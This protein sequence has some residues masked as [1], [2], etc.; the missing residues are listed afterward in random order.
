[1]CTYGDS[2]LFL[3]ICTRK[4][5]TNHSKETFEKD[6]YQE[7]KIEDKWKRI[8]R[9][10]LVILSIVTASVFCIMVLFNKAL[11]I[12]LLPCSLLY[13]LEQSNKA[14][15]DIEVVQKAFKQSIDE[16]LS[17]LEWNSLVGIA[18]FMC[19]VNLYKIPNKIII[20]IEGIKNDRLS[21][22]ILIIF[23]IFISTI[24][25]FLTGVLIF[26]LIKNIILFFETVFYK[27]KWSICRRICTRLIGKSEKIFSWDFLSIL[28]CERMKRNV[29]IM[30]IAIVPII[31]IDVLL[32]QLYILYRVVLS[33]IVNLVFFLKSTKKLLGHI[34]TRMKEVSDRSIAIIFFRISF[35]VSVMSLVVYNRYD[36]LIKEYAKGT[37]SLEFVSSA[38]VIPLLLSWIVDLKSKLY[39]AE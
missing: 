27:G 19:F 37:A 8:M 18:A 13:F 33:C 17:L 20:Q 7:V 6:I 38:I 25:I 39:V 3:N 1:M 35:I 23:L 15:H 11:A 30:M 26:S 36:P 24:Y 28:F 12:I 9:K 10:I 21:D 4:D 16:P 34:S 31:I 14:Y 5:I 32:K 2:C 29:I 22:F